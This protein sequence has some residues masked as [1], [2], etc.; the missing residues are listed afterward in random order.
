[1]PLN[2]I[3]TFFHPEIRSLIDSALEQAWLELREDGPDDEVM[4]P[5]KR[6]DNCRFGGNRG[7]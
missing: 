4:A 5:R 1:M 2:E 6:H 3:P 7:N